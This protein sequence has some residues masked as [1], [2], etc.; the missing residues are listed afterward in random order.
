LISSR[1]AD[2]APKPEGVNR[3]EDVPR[4]RGGPSPRKDQLLKKNGL[5]RIKRETVLL[6]SQRQLGMAAGGQTTGLVA[7]SSHIASC[8]WPD[9]PAV[10]TIFTN[11][12]CP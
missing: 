3:R 8:C 9:P 11:V 5:L 4:L 7:S 6:L 2:S 10:P 12:N 1:R